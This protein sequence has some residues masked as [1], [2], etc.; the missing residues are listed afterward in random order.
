[1]AARHDCF[2]ASAPRSVRRPYRWDVGRE[3]KEDRSLR[4]QMV[5]QV[6]ALGG[7]RDPE[8]EWPRAH[9]AMVDCML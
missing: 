5:R 3:K 1:M 2:D 7:Y 9:E 6:V 4:M 8:T